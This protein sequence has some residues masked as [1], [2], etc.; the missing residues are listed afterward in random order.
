LHAVNVGFFGDSR[1]G[2]RYNETESTRSMMPLAIRIFLPLP[3]APT[4]HAI[5]S[6][7][8]AIAQTIHA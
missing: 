7:A 3:D 1:E 5:R 4:R 2:R 8:H 6:S